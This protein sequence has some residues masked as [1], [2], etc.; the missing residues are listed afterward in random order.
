MRTRTLSRLSPIAGLLL[1]SITITGC[2]GST[3]PEPA[4]RFETLSATSANALVGATVNPSPVVR[5]IDGSN[6]PVAGIAV[7]FFPVNGGTVSNRKVTTGTDGLASAGTWTLGTRAM[8]YT[9]RAQATGL[10]PVVFTAVAAA[11]PPKLV[12]PVSGDRQTANTGAPLLLPLRALVTDTFGNRV[13]NIPV[14]F[15]V[16]SGG[17]TLTDGPPLTDANGFA[18]SGVWS[19][20]PIAGEQQVRAVMQ[21]GGAEYVFKASA[22]DPTC[23]SFAL[24]FMRN[25]GIYRTTQGGRVSLIANVNGWSPAVSRDGSR[26]ALVRSETD[27]T[28]GVVVMDL[29]GKNVRR[30]LMDAYDPSWSPDGSRLAVVAGF[31]E[32]T[33]GI[34]ILSVNDN[35]AAVKLDVRGIQP[36]WSP[37]GKKIAFVSV[38]DANGHQALHVVNVDGTGLT[39]LSQRDGFLGHPSWSPDGTRIAYSKCELECDIHVV[40]ADGSSSQQLTNTGKASSPDWSP[41]GSW[42]AVSIFD[43][44]TEEAAIGYVDP[45]KGGNPILLQTEAWSPVWIPSQTGA[46]R[47]DRARRD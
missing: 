45:E 10:D 33:C 19:L 32:F 15:T 26:I 30:L 43:Y 23:Q 41:D 25:G 5:V 16:V 18:V 20:G 37:D 22:C 6:Q 38:G 47:V 29:N 12:R 3:D 13:G 2:E 11:G 36:A 46:L 40:R 1:T 27:E 44:T 4:L 14:T 39:V 7:T 31:C 24:L 9:L 35:A 42:I 34:Y 28:S 8:Q 21:G 17:G